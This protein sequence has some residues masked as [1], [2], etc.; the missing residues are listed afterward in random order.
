MH[1]HKVVHDAD[2]MAE[3]TVTI[4]QLLQRADYETAFS[5]KWHMG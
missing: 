5:G 4:P 1:N 3:R 2:R